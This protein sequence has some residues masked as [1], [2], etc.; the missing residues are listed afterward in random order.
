MSATLTSLSPELLVHIL[1]LLSSPKDLYSAIAAS[2]RLYR[3]FI[4]EPR[5]RLL[6]QRT[7]A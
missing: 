7:T 3:I 4:A 5:V 1:G 6:G 2:S